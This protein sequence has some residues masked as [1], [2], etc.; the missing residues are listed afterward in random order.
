MVYIQTDLS[1]FK[2]GKKMG[3]DARFWPHFILLLGVIYLG[4]NG[5]LTLSTKTFNV[6]FTRRRQVEG[7]PAIV[8]G[9]VMVL[10]GLWCLV[11]LIY[12]LMN[13]VVFLFHGF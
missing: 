1:P 2:K 13:G 6:P 10:L 11:A 4:F 8:V 7:K 12:M 5:L 9:I 3:Y